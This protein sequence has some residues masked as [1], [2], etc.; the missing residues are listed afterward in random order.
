MSSKSGSTV[1]AWPVTIA[2]AAT[3]TVRKGKGIQKIKIQ[4]ESA[5]V[6][7]KKDA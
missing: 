1:I 2:I 6:I 4:N 3:T 5:I 7:L